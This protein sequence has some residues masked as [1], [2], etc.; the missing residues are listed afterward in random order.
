MQ[1]EKEKYAS[2]NVEI[3]NLYKLTLYIVDNWDPPPRKCRNDKEH[4]R[5]R[6]QE[7]IN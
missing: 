2:N 5:K 6:K 7:I 1:R 4:E 3:H